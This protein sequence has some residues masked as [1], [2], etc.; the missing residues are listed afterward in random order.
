VSFKVCLNDER[1]T[2]KEAFKTFPHFFFEGVA[3]NLNT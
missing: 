1:A 2:Q 3:I